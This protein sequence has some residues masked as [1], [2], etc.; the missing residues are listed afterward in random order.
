[1][2]LAD[3]SALGLAG[4]DDTELPVRNTAARGFQEK[5]LSGSGCFDSGRHRPDGT[6]CCLILEGD[7]RTAALVGLEAGAEIIVS[8]TVA[9]SGEN[10]MIAGSPREVHVFDVDCRAV[11]TRTAAVLG[12]FSLNHRS[13][14]QRGQARSQAS[15]RTADQLITAILEGWTVNVNLTMLHVTNA[16]FQALEDLKARVRSGIRGVSD[17]MR[18]GF[19]GIRGHARSGFRNPFD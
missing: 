14:L 12:R 10:R 18:P 1:M 7:D 2:E 13:A 6:G 5:R 17:V 9:R 3:R 15:E 8:G 19:H 16:D 4:P 11:N